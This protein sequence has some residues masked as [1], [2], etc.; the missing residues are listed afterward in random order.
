MRRADMPALNLK[1]L[2]F[3]ELKLPQMTRDDIGKGLGEARKELGEFRRDL[4]AFRREM[5]MPRVDL[6]K[7]EIPKVEV[8]REA[9]K[10]AKEAHKAA[11]N[12][13]RGVTKAAQ[14]AG[15]VKKPVSRLPIVV[16]AAVTL[17][18]VGWAL[19]NSPSIRERLRAAAQKFQ[20]RMA[21]RG[22]PWAL[23]DEHEPRAFDSAVPAPVQPSAF[24]DALPGADSP[25]AE[26]PSDLP[27]GFGKTNGTHKI[28]SDAPAR[29]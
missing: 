8:P 16:A 7:I 25:F 14:D 3:P 20:D 22:D 10:A 29:A 1:D 6:S 5:E 12:A 9:R 13:G 28:E 15:L 11:R 18:L 4:D 23:D 2:K 21:Q 17:G 24:G 27:D 19:A 26:P